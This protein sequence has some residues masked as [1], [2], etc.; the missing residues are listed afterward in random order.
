ML[1]EGFLHYP[2]VANYNICS[3]RST[4]LKIINAHNNAL[5]S[6]K[7]E[8]PS[9]FEDEADDP[10]CHVS[11]ITNGQS[12][13]C[14]VCEL[15][16]CGN[17]DEL[18]LHVDQ[19]LKS[20]HSSENSSTSTQRVQDNAEDN[21]SSLSLQFEEYEWAG[22]TR[23]RVSTLSRSCRERLFDGYIPPKTEC[24]DEEVDVDGEYCY[25]QIQYTEAD[26]ARY[27][28]RSESEYSSLS[29][30]SDKKYNSCQICLDP[31]KAPIVSV[32]CWHVHCKRCWLRSLG[33]KKLCP[34]C[35]MITTAADLRRVYL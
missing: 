28:D 24:L 7:A 23:V 29:V 3:F 32:V 1:R 12:L 27:R 15:F 18:Q 33:E 35:C 11:S 26:V 2:N 34:R 25:G 10:A 4:R 30:E 6:D 9:T 20:F 17:M 19:C 22:Q 31:L 16:F 13:S 8:K 21:S 14:C 5:D